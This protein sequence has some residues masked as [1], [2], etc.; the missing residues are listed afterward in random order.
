MK[1]VIWLF[2]LFYGSSLMAD[3][4]Y[5]P[6]IKERIEI[7]CPGAEIV[8]IEFREGFTEVEFLCN[9]HKIEAGF[10]EHHQMVYTKTDV[11][12]DVQIYEKIIKKIDK[13]Y[14]GWKMDDFQLV[15]TPDT[16][17]YVVE[18]VKHG[19]E[20]N[21][22]FTTNGSYYRPANMSAG[23]KLNDELT[24]SLYSI[25]QPPYDFSQPDHIFYLPEVLREVSGI[26]PVSEHSMYL[27]QDELGAVF[28]FNLTKEEVTGMVRF[29]DM[30]DFEDVAT[31]GSH[32]FVLRSDGTVFRFHPA[33]PEEAPEMMRVPVQVTNLEGLFYDRTEKHLL[34]AGKSEPVNGD[35]DLR[36][37]YRLKPEEMHQPEVWLQISILEINDMLTKHFPSL[38]MLNYSFT[39]NPS[40]IAIH[41]KTGETYILSASDRLLAIFEDKKLKEVF[42]LSGEIHY[43]PKA[44]L[45]QPMETFTCQAKV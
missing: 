3:T 6:V 19:I 22:Y 41:P 43:K 14:A 8:D 32:V 17:F 26:V 36:L 39:F 45:S 16:T 15:E 10:D 29:T 21:V 20:E 18:M 35:D 23:E 25:R 34:M 1:A 30:G 42:P 37:V 33:K 31:D 13:S 28:E 40:A 12:A 44:W 24:A 2:A 4:T 7:L 9:G 27:I 5:L 11:E 38:T